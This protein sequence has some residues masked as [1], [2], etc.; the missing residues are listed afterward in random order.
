MEHGLCIIPISSYAILDISGRCY[1]PSDEVL[2]ALLVRFEPENSSEFY[3]M[4]YLAG[5]LYFLV[6]SYSNYLITA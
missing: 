2:E 4:R 1:L 3:Q 6:S 5:L